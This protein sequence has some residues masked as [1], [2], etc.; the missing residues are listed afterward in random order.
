MDVER[1]I[2]EDFKTIE[3][4]DG[5]AVEAA[6]NLDEVVQGVV[7]SKVTTREKV[8]LALGWANTYMAAMLK[9]GMT[10]EEADKLVHLAGVRVSQKMIREIQEIKYLGTALDAASR[11][12]FK[13][14]DPSKPK[15]YMVIV[16]FV[17]TVVVLALCL[18][19]L[20]I[21]KAV[22]YTVKAVK[23]LWGKIPETSKGVGIGEPVPATA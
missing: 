20:A 6:K 11:W 23:Y 15:W 10:D 19:A 7:A 12:I 18:I 13:D 9:A 5:E 8:R 3:V 14:K 22:Q 16:R 2:L 17:W 21:K 1:I 4:Q